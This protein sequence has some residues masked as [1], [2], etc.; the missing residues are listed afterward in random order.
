M[1]DDEQTA[2]DPAA[3]SEPADG[4]ADESPPDQA[5]GAGLGRV[6]HFEPEPPGR[7]LPRPGPDRPPRA[8]R[9]GARRVLPWAGLVLFAGCLYGLLNGS[10]PMTAPPPVPGA[11][12]PEGVV[13]VIDPGHGGADSGAIAQGMLEKDLNLDVGLRVARVLQASGL[14][15]KLT[16]ADDRFVP[17]EARVEMANALPGAIFVSIHFN[18]AQGEGRTVSRASG[19][20]T[21]YSGVKQVAPARDSVWTALFRRSKAAANPA[22]ADAVRAGALLADCIQHALIAETAAAD[23]GIKEAGLY[24][25]RR[26]RGPAVLVEGGFVSHPQE[27]RLLQDPGYR[28]TIANAIA[29]GIVRFLEAAQPAAGGP[30][31]PRV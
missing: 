16:R 2:A 18:D 8:R 24:V 12:A 4:V 21:Y 7:T 13:I 5:A 29:E 25:T 26:V 9:S 3:G 19:I 14:T 28:Q 31:P 1:P 22:P 20:E 10:H 11:F 17:L 6:P 23:R 30:P 27:A 15:V